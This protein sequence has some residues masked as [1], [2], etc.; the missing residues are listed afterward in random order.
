MVFVFL[1]LT[2]LCM[3]DS[4]S[5]HISTN[6]PVSS[7]CSL[8][9]G[10]WCWFQFLPLMS[11]ILCTFALRASLV[12]QMVKDPPAIW[13][14]WVWSLGWE[15]LLEKGTVTHSSTLACGVP[16]IESLTGYS[17]WG[18]RE[19]DMTRR[20]SLS[21]LFSSRKQNVPLQ[22][23]LLLI[24]KASPWDLKREF[25]WGSLFHVYESEC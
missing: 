16:W 14:T 15:D 13:E 24:I 12:A 3:T 10:H 9:G 21:Y 19:S 11:K 20:L 25:L 23:G 17:L 2:S 5:I 6:D 22:E 8:V 7:I 4:R 18:H 1:D